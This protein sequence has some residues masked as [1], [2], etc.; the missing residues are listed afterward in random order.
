V[1]KSGDRFIRSDTTPTCDRQ[2]DGRTDTHLPIDTIGTVKVQ[3]TQLSQR[4]RAMLR[5]VKNC[6]LR[7]F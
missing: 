7:S 5:V 2:T 1:E 3:Q 4:G 6:H